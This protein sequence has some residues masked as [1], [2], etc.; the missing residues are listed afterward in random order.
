LEKEM[1]R[2]LVIASCLV[3]GISL[4]AQ[5][6]Y[7]ALPRTT[8]TLEV[9]A[10]Q[11]SFFAGP[12][13]AFAHRLLNM[14]VREDDEVSTE[15]VSARLI[16]QVEADPSA[17]YTTEQDNASLL[18]LSAQGLVS[19]ADKAEG[20]TVA[21]RFPAKARAHFN[22]ALITDTEKPSTIIEFEA[23]Q[24]DTGM[25]NVPIEH[26]I[27]VE[28]TLE[29]KASDA[30]DM[31]LNLRKER[32]NIITG[33]TDANFYGNSM[34]IALRELDRMEKE[35]LALFQGFTVVKT[36]SASFDIIPTGGNRP[37][38]Y[39]AFRLLE[40]RF[41][42]DGTRGVPYYL[43]L[44]PEAL[45]TGE[46]SGSQ[47]RSKTNPLHYRTPVVCKVSLT[48]D[49]QTLLSARVPVY[50]LGMEGQYPNNK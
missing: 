28:K 36:F 19:F 35:Y 1:K 26:K 30:A 22:G 45:K 18:T 13:A 21:W 12:Y 47:R 34:E 40:D 7:Y 8:F 10:R 44:E 11:E 15:I 2:L 37:Q 49:N 20:E 32:M 25:V 48:K 5:E 38:Q 23:V 6:L 41:A 42:T 43:Q 31:I 3:L 14:D 27:L 29:D 16:P 24:T 9:Q 4:Q 39:L 46:E 50:Q 33:N 17:W